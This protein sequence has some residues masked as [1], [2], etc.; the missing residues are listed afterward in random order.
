MIGWLVKYK[1]KYISTM[2][3]FSDNEVDVFLTDNIR[4]AQIFLE[5]NPNDIIHN[6]FIFYGIDCNDLKYIKLKIEFVD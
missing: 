6:D 5:E 4:V 3:Q 2:E 1:D